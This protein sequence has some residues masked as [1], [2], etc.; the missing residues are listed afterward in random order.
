MLSK[1]IKQTI[2]N[3]II[4]YESYEEHEN[5]LAIELKDSAYEL[6][7]DLLEENKKYHF[8]ELAESIKDKIFKMLLKDRT[9]W[10]EDLPKEIVARLNIW[11]Y[12]SENDKE[13]KTIAEW[14]YFAQNS[15]NA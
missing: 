14:Y 1:N 10:D 13:P 9:F 4:N 11:G 6:L 3:W 15:K 12:I 8:S 7:K 2:K 5:W